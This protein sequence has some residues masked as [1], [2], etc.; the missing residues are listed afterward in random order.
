MDDP[1]HLQLAM[2]RA[3]LMARKRQEI[4]KLAPEKALTRILEDPQAAALVHSFPEEDLYFLIHAIGPEDSLPLLNLASNKQ[5]AYIMDLDSWD[6]D[7]IDLNAL[8]RWLN[9]L[10]Q[11]DPQRFI[12][13]C[14]KEKL[15]VLEFYLFKNI[16]IRI[17]E[18]DQEPSEFGEDYFTQDDV[19][20][21]RILDPP[22][23]TDVD[24]IADEQRRTFLT[25]LIERLA[26]HDYAAYHNVLLESTATV[27][28]EIEEDAYRWRN[29]RLAEKGFLPF[30]EAV[31]VY[32]PMSPT[33]LQNR[34]PKSLPPPERDELSRLPVPLTPIELLSEDTPFTRAL[35]HIDV[36]AEMQQLQS[37]FANLCNQLI[38]ADRRIVRDKDAL[39]DIVKKASGYVSI[40]LQCLS[41]DP[42]KVQ[43]HQAAALI[44]HHGLT[45]LFRVGFGKGLALKWQAEKWLPASWF[46][47]T[48][49]RLTFWGEEWLG[50]LGGLLIKKPLFFDNYQ[51]GSMYREFLC[52]DDI[53]LTETA[54]E[55]IKAVDD[56]LGILAIQVK[57]VSAYGFLTYKSLLL[58]SWARHCSGLSTKTLKPL[59]LNRFKVFFDRLF[60]G[61]AAADSAGARSI[62]QAQKESFLRWLAAA[63]GL[64]DYELSERLGTT[65]QALFREVESEY[66]RVA[67]NAL[68]PR[69]IHLFLIEH[70]GS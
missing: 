57:P 31:G 12:S 40:A 66:G 65:L 21:L 44:K 49:L 56:L 35:Q 52:M 14:L 68:D 51:T 48:G 8:T 69:F 19:V 4:A 6:R 29:I 64:K 43:A 70:P 34:R 5:W 24:S 62:P 25:R 9:L 23:G 58:T 10:L 30:D 28:A 53:R 17:R 38:V 15:D 67:V 50:V 54:F 13:W 11:A 60:G 59:S 32:Q 20:Y 37:E 18:H 33:T 61:A 36:N 26:A 22:P 3:Q 1:K 16:E 42:Q 46:V 47:R 45:E 7:R 39:R 55:Q 41:K 2:Q 63:S 27:A